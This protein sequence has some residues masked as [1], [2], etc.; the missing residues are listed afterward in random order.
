MSRGSCDGHSPGETDVLL[1][2]LPLGMLLIFCNAQDRP[3]PH[4]E[5]LYGPKC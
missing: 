2:S 3:S 1:A 4:P 5:E